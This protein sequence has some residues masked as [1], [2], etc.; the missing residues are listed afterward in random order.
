[1]SGSIPVSG[2]GQIKVS[3]KD[4]SADSQAIFP[5]IQFVFEILY[6]HSGSDAKPVALSDFVIKSRMRVGNDNTLYTVGNLLVS[7]P[8]LKL[9]PSNTNVFETYL[10]LDFYRLSQIEKLREG[11]DV[12]FQILGWFNS[13][14]VQGGEKQWT[15]FWMDV[16]IPKSDWVEKILSEVGFKNVSLL[17]IPRVSSE[18]FK[19]VTKW[20]DSAWK[21]Y[22][23]GEYDK[24]LGDCRKALEGLGSV[25][26]G[27]GFETI[28]TENGKRRRLPNWDKYLGDNKELGDIFSG[29]IQ[30]TTGFITPGSHFGKGIN[31]EDADLA[32]M[33]THS[34]VNFIIKK[35]PES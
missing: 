34:L 19:D 15:Q 1:M 30:K 12:I 25:V 14:T 33:T 9:F 2:G 5:R 29:F 18:E 20:V 32:L 24:V 17:E 11:K 31:R 10:D 21:Q 28:V 23:M 26:K 4:F 8:Y 22:M 16:R 6:T 3:C 13:E 35:N 7:N 27:K